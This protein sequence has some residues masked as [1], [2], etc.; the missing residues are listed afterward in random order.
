MSAPGFWGDQ[1]RAQATVKEM[2]TAKGVV[3]TFEEVARE[4]ID[5]GDLLA[6][7]V[8]EDDASTVGEIE[9]SLPG[10]RKAL[11]SLELRS[12]LS[13]PQ[14]R[15]GAVVSI[16]PGAGG[17]ESQDWAEM[18]RRMYLRWAER[19]GFATEFLDHQ[20][21]EEAGIK[22][23]TVAVNGDYAFGYLKGESGVHRLVRISPFDSSGR[24]HTSF[25]SVFVYPQ[26]DETIEVEIADSE[27][28]ID[29]FRAS[30]AGGQHINKTDSAVR[31]THLPTGLA[32][33]SQNERSQHRNRDNAFKILK[34][35]LYALKLEEERRK[36]DTLYDQ[37]KE[38]A[39]GS[40]IR[41]YVF[42]PYTMIKD[43]RTNFEMGDV[44]R[45]M[46]GDLEGF[47]NAWLKSVHTNPAGKKP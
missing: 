32:V 30:G 18:L 8:E 2:K 17:T 35:R 36:L 10:L 39:W 25:A 29:T 28:R 5:T 11:D 12:F 37:Q 43:H 22:D 1:E 16:H 46:D 7:G 19:E 3:E 45:V 15:L 42:Q 6:L 31:I 24:R 9:S 38:I 14:D 21:A 41:S 20:I 40:Q 34:A 26:V 23:A 27:I 4:V 44:Q 47:M 33:S 13:D